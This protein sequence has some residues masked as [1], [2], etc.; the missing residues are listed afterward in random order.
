[1]N[2]KEQL[3]ND[4]IPRIKEMVKREE[5]HLENLKKYKRKSSNKI[6]NFISLFNIND[7]INRSSET[8]NHLKTRLKEYVEYSVL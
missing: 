2:F 3:I 1:M 7:M 4:F 8:L 6:F 5:E